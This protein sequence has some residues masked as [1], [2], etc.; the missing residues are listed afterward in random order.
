MSNLS[1]LLQSRRAN[2]D[3]SD[4][5][6]L[7][8][9][10]DAKAPLASPALTGVPTAPTATAGTSTT[11]IA[12]TAYVLENK[13]V[14]LVASTTTGAAQTVDFSNDY[15]IVTTDPVTTLSFLSTKPVEEVNVV[16][17]L[18]ADPT[19]DIEN[20]SYTGTLITS[21]PGSLPR[22]PHFS[23]DGSRLYYSGTD[24]TVH[25]VTLRRPYDVTTRLAFTSLSIAAQ[26]TSINTSTLS[27]DGTVLH[28]IDQPGDRILRYTLS[29][30]YEVSTGTYSLAYNLTTPLIT[31]PIGMGISSDGTKMFICDG[32]TDI[33]YMYNLST[34]FDVSTA[35]YSND[36]FS[37]SG[38][39]PNSFGI[40][41]TG[42]RIYWTFSSSG[43]KK[44]YQAVLSVPYDITTVGT[45]SDYEHFPEFGTSTPYLVCFNDTG[46]VLYAA[47]G[48]GLWKYNLGASSHA[49]SFPVGTGVGSLKSP[50]LSPSIGPNIYRFATHDSG[51]TYILTAK[52][53]GIRGY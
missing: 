32:T 48:G 35:T 49:V 21:W 36:S 27:P 16:V 19:Y 12:T 33:V 30:P 41:P 45:I 6:T 23:P 8:A 38:Y 40:S 18:G 44:T 2:F 28:V 37:L 1:T 31:S 51:A 3:I 10:L 52:L 47:G 43:T 13:G 22:F 46:D 17:N 26:S 50:N 42:N 53:E 9:T 5:N 11:Q 14:D 7:Q 15:Q 29:T 39:N 34:A 20:L 25:Q 24:S 4:V